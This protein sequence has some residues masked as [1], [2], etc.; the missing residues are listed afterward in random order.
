MTER[1]GGSDVS[2]TETRAVRSS[3]N[4]AEAMGAEVWE[5]DGFKWFS[6]ATDGDVALAL[7]RTGPEAAGA[8]SI[9]LFFVPLRLPLLKSP[10]ATQ[11]SAL[12]SE[13]TLPRSV[14]RASHLVL[15]NASSAALSSNNGILIHRLKSKVGTWPVPTAELSLNQT[16]GCRIGELNQGVKLITPV[17][18]ITRIHSAIDSVSYLARCLQIAKAYA[19]VREVA[20]AS[21]GGGPAGRA[22]LRDVPLHTHTLAKVEVTYRALLQLV[23]GAVTLLGR[24]EYFTSST[25]R[26]HGALHKVDEENAWSAEEDVALL[27]LLTPVV[28][29]YISHYAAGGMEEC[30]I[31]LGGQGY[32]EETG[33]G[34][35]IRD[36]LVEK[37]W[38]GTPNI[39]AL[40]VLR[41]CRGGQSG[42]AFIK[43]AQKQ[44]SNI[45]SVLHAKAQP[46]ISVLRSAILELESLLIPLPSSATSQPSTVLPRPLFFL[47]GHSASALFLLEHTLWSLDPSSGESENEREA[48]IAAFI[49][50]VQDGPTG[51][52]LAQAIYEVE[53]VVQESSGP[54]VDQLDELL[55]YGGAS[56]RNT[57]SGAKL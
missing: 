22:L 38:E 20:S 37:I 13:S 5:L 36:A 21:A 29:G 49:R 17:L 51:A 4:S 2:L 45:P 57:R 1:P 28:K 10:P 43:F 25:A 9:S 3:N 7:A 53:K 32:M 8:R 40:D 54:S 15:S 16:L 50:W 47:L 6:S 26:A 30:M 24:V 12:L 35:M 34:R 14:T 56:T 39:M 27:R 31:A 23:F 19:G 55:V 42:R 44:L 33:I 52:G 41:A 11:L 48:G 18:N 46:Q